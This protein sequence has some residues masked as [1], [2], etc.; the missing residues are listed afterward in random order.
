MCECMSTCRLS[1]GTLAT[2]ASGKIIGDRYNGL[3]FPQ[4]VLPGHDSPF[5]QRVQKNDNNNFGPRVGFAWDP[6]GNGKMSL[7]GGYGIYYDRT[8]I[9]I[10]EQNGFSDPLANQTSNFD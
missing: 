8:L 3:I 4:G 10:V 5:G 9:G 1:N 2:D 6:F 7:R